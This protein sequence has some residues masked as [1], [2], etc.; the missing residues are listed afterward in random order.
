MRDKREQPDFAELVNHYISQSGY[1]VCQLARLSSVPRTTLM[2]WLSGTVKKPRVWQDIVKLAKALHLDESESNLLLGAAGNPTLIHFEA[3]ARSEE[4]RQLLGFWRKETSSAY[5]STPFQAVP[6]LPTFVGRGT[7]MRTLEEWLLTNY[8]DAPAIL[9]GTG[10]VGKTALAARFAYRWRSHFPDGVLWARPDTS[11]PMTILRQFAEAFGRDVTNY[12][13][14]G[15]RSAVV[16]ELLANKQ[17]LLVL[18]NVQNSHQIE[19]LLAPSGS[20]AALITTRRRNLALVGSDH[21]LHLD[22]FTDIESMALFVRILSEER[23]GNESAILAEIA[24]TV[25]QLPLAID[26]VASRL[27]Y[28]P[29]WKT[30]DFLAYLQRESN[31]LIN[32]AHEERCVRSAFTTSYAQL[33]PEQ[34]RFFAALGAFGGEDFSVEAA[35]AIV[36]ID[37]AEADDNLKA[38]FCLSLLRRGRPG[39]YRLTPLLRVFARGEI[40]EEA[41]WQHLV[42]YFVTYTEQH[43][44]ELNVLDVEKNNIFAALAAARERGL[45]SDLE[46]GQNA[47]S[48]FLQQG[49][50]SGLDLEAIAY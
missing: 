48:Y 22:S 23:V 30:A 38:L 35:A 24:N 49:G 3:Q 16:R 9:V 8:H 14:L 50:L 4:E 37:E 45:S 40:E 18:D 36:A 32:L 29:G 1:N 39:R 47:F 26:I 33:T 41:V 31:L 6:D 5:R 34:Q 44:K 21:R 13:D 42:A 11:N 20:C 12:E 43:E 15:S 46:R 2:S 27:A 28:E 19:S 17:A 10:G 7:A 25:G